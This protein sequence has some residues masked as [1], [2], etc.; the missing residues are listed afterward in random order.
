[1]SGANIC[2][3]CQRPVCECIWL[4]SRGKTLVNGCTAEPSTILCDKRHLKTFHITGCPLYVAPERKEPK[5]KSAHR[6]KLTGY[7]YFCGSPLTGRQRKY[8]KSCLEKYG[9][10]FS[11]DY[12]ERKKMGR[13]LHDS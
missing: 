9:D 6:P 11:S 10:R 13:D 3:D 5:R 8:C 7:C 12:A 4:M 2:S 1:M